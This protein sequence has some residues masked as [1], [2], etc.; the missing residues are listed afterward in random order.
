MIPTPQSTGSTL[1]VGDVNGSNSVFIKN[2]LVKNNEIIFGSHVQ[3]IQIYS[4]SGQ[5][6]KTSN[7]KGS[8]KVN[9]ADLPKGNYIVIG[10]VNDRKVTERIIKD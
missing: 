9:V 10:T 6:V 8:A 4:M 2:T 7:V 3:S 5:L 1:E